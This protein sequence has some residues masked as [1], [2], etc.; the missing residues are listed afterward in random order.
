MAGVAPL[1]VI[2]PIA[3]NTEN[4]EPCT[5]TDVP[6]GP[7]FGV[8]VITEEVTVNL[9]EAVSAGTVPTLLHDRMIVYAPGVIAGTMNVHVKV[10]VA[11][12]V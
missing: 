11:E 6:L 2:V 3:V 10:P 1:N 9:V 8:N 5:V 7:W 4:P 12:V